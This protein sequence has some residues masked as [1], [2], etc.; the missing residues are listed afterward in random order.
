M[1]AHVRWSADTLGVAAAA[2]GDADRLP[3]GNIL[4]PAWPS[5]VDPGAATDAKFDAVLYEVHCPSGAAAW[6]LTVES[7]Q[8][9]FAPD[10]YN[11]VGQNAR[12]LPLGWAI[13][14]AERLFDAPLLANPRVDAVV[15]ERGW[16]VSCDAFAATRGAVARRATLTA[17]CA[18]SVE[19]HVIAADE[20]N[21]SPGWGRARASV[22]ISLDKCISGDVRLRVVEYDLSLI[23]I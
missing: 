15:R 16:Q 18:S 22:W 7:W 20:V 12:A 23:H 13:Y 8:T 3:S 19:D 6:K 11:H 5:T 17:S 10:G 2:F 14:S 1:V 21:L 9:W 4:G